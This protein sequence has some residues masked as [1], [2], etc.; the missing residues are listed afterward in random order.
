MAPRPAQLWEVAIG[1]FAFPQLCPNS[2][3]PK[4]MDR[5]SEGFWGSILELLRLRPR[6]NS[7]PVGFQKLLARLR[8]SAGLHSRRARDVTAEGRIRVDSVFRLH[9]GQRSTKSRGSRARPRRGASI[10]GR[11]VPL[12]ASL[13]WK[14]SASLRA[15]GK[16]V[17]ASPAQRL[18]PAFD[19]ELV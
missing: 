18:S 15:R 12:V 10:S 3:C 9:V 19:R 7:N 5:Y 8:P 16:G 1:S 4:R 6:Q 2:K 14:S 13:R 11:R 17:A